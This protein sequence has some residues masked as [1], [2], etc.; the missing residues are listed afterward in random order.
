MLCEEQ[1]FLVLE[2]WSLLWGYGRR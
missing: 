2:V 1:T